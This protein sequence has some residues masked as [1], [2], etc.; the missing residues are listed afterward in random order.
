[1]TAA[2]KRALVRTKLKEQFKG[3]HKAKFQNYKKVNDTE[4]Q[5]NVIKLPDESETF[6]VD[7]DNEEMSPEGK[8]IQDLVNE[9]KGERKQQGVYR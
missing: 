3:F 1:M 7:L 4:N 2:R 8:K 6:S 9:T 5:R